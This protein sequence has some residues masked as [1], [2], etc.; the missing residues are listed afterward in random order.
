MQFLQRIFLIGEFTLASTTA[1]AAA[2]VDSGALDP[3][4]G[5]GGKVQISAAATGAGGSNLVA[6]DVA[7]Q[8][9]G[10][11]IVVGYNDN[12]DCV[13]A[14]LNVDG[15]RDANF[16][17]TNSFMPGFAGYGNC[18]FTGIAVRADDRIVVAANQP[19]AASF[20]SQFT[21]DGVPD[22]TFGQIYASSYITPV[23][24]DSTNLARVMIE[25]NGTIDTVGTYHDNA[26]NVNRFMFVQ[27]SADGKTVAPLFTYEFGSGN[28]QDD[29]ALDL[30]IDTQGRYVVG[31]YHRGANGNYDCAVIRIQHSL[32]DVDLSFG[33]GGQTIVA[34]DLGGDNGDFCN[35]LTVVK[36][37]NYIVLGGHA[38]AT[39]G[40]GTYQAAV[41]AMLD[42]TGHYVQYGC[43]A[44]CLP[45]KFAFAFDNNPRAGLTNDITKLIVSG[46]DTRYQ[47]IYAVGSGYQSGT[48][49]G[50][51]FGIARLNLTGPFNLDT[52]LNSAGSVGV[53]FR[54]HPN[55]FGLLSTNN[56]GMSATLNGGKLVVVGY[57][58][59]GGTNAMAVTRLSAFD[60]IFKNGYDAPYY[61]PSFS[62][63]ATNM[64]RFSSTVLKLA[65]AGLSMD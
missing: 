56:T 55:G 24:G 9:N 31:G 27:M 11:T 7:V 21:A 65:T 17:G 13:L 12:N 51:M 6:T 29:H 26:R 40:S 1:F 36:P 32:Y 22:A 30:G 34:F 47:Q 35:A 23:S 58:S 2:P 57:T 14:R 15:S 3:S 43:A 64:I 61:S 41:V 10:K 50:N 45:E 28:N 52:S 48:P 63:D 20:I 46:Y 49:Y 18:S 62:F 19:Y 37:S 38:T 25:S 60:G 44:V 59:T 5:L 8:S 4:F 33:S 16:G 54:E 42:N 39:V 53:Y